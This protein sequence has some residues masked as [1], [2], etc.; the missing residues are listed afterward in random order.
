MYVQCKQGFVEA[1]RW[2]GNPI[3]DATHM[4]ELVEARDKFAHRDHDRGALTVIVMRSRE[5]DTIEDLLEY[6]TRRVRVLASPP[7]WDYEFRA[8]VTAAEWA[9]IL[10]AVVEEI[11]Y[12]N[13]KSWSGAHSNPAR[14]RMAHSIWHACHDAFPQHHDRQLFTSL[15]QAIAD[16]GKLRAPQWSDPLDP[17]SIEDDDRF[18]KS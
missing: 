15:G 11:D 4:A 5:E 3:P 16:D 12:R 2:D 9:A 10:A 1:D 17:L 14:V 7:T 13:F 18:D 6:L 8:Y